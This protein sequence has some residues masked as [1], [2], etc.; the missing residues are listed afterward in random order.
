[1]TWIVLSLLSALFLGLYDVLKK[2]SLEGNAVPPVLLCSVVTGALLWLPCLGL[3]QAGWLHAGWGELYVRPLSAGEHGLLFVKSALVGCSWTCAFFALKHLPISIAS[4]VRATSPLWTVMIAVLAM[5]ERPGG[6]QWLGIGVILLAFIAFSQLG[7]AE[8]IRFHRNAWV[9]LMLVATGLG[10]L[11]ALYDKYL[12]QTVGLGAGTV[13]AWFSVYL[14]PVMLPLCL[15]WFWKERRSKP[16]QW[17]WSI[18]LIATSLLVADFLYFSALRDPAALIS[19]VSPIRRTSVIVTY[20][21][22]ILWLREKSW[23]G[24]GLCIILLLAG[25]YLVS[26]G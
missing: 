1:M 8:G 15:R 2:A 3:S 24:K 26:L 21:A 25:V 20:A 19:V 5:G 9:A 11:S 17:R 12:L 16:F 6:W 13:Q 7:K 22:G 14:V 23:R 18:P 10:S 4:P